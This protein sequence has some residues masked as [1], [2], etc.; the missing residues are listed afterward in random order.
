MM[1]WQPC[2]AAHYDA[3]T[4]M[5]QVREDEIMPRLIAARVTTITELADSQIGGNV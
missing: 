4:V 5:I 3:S 2:L 1:L